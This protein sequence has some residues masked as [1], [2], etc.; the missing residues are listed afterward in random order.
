MEL[1]S[2]MVFWHWFVIAIILIVA[3]IFTM[4]MFALFVAI[5]AV[6]VGITSWIF[7]DFPVEAQFIAWSVLSLL[8]LVVWHFYRKANPPAE[9][10]QPSLNR[11]GTQYVDRVF[12]LDEP[13]VNGTGKIKVDDS[14]WKVVCDVDMKKGE[15]VKVSAVDGVVLKVVK[16]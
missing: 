1:F 4:S 15:K 6:L 8:S 3:E 11:R 14:T 16:A 9:T 12:T 7:P 2:D 13:I 5:A 10:D